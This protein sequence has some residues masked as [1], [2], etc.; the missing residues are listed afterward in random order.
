VE[1]SGTYLKG[2]HIV[3]IYLK[4]FIFK[5]LKSCIIFVFISL[6]A[7]SSKRIKNLCIRIILSPELEPGKKK[8]GGPSDITGCVVV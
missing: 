1:S 8:S 6:G 7:A 5:E 2:M 3:I 4:S